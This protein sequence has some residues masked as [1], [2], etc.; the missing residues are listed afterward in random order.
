MPGVGEIGQGARPTGKELVSASS[1]REGEVNA[2]GG[3]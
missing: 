1:G 3:G 2:W